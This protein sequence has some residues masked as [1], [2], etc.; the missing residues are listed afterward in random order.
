MKPEYIFG[1]RVLRRAAA[2]LLEERT[3]YEGLLR[4][5]QQ[6]LRW[7]SAEGDLPPPLQRRVN[8]WRAALAG[9]ERHINDHRT[10]LLRLRTLGPVQAERHARDLVALADDARAQIAQ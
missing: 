9:G 1:R 6:H 7:L 5:D 2:V 3:A 10:L 8:A 4:A